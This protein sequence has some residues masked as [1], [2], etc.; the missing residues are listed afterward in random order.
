MDQIVDD[1]V[2]RLD[3]Y[4]ERYYILG[5][6]SNELTH[7]VPVLACRQIKAT[8]LANIHIHYLPS[9]RQLDELHKGFFQFRFMVN[10][11]I[12]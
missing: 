3:V 5:T 2:R 1:S 8:V 4:V 10:I 12:K 6:R 11:R 9:R 7:I